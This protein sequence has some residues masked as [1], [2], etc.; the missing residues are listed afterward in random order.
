MLE[1]TLM[2]AH[3]VREFRFEALPDRVPVPMAQLTVRA[4][5]GIWLRVTRRDANGAQ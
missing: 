5:D 1:G 2:L 3:L 4:R